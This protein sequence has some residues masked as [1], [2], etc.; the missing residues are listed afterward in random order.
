MKGVEDYKYFYSVFKYTSAGYLFAILGLSLSNTF[1][2]ISIPSENM[3]AAGFFG[4]L[5]GVYAALNFTVLKHEHA[6]KKFVY[7]LLAFIGYPVVLV[8]GLYSLVKL[9]FF[10]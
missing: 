3:G 10:L 7:P 5:L 8:L 1:G 6:W 4:G 9:K 2:L